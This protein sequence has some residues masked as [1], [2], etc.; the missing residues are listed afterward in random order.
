M[1]EQPRQPRQPSRLLS[2]EALAEMLDVSVYTVKR[3]RRER[4]GPRG[5]RVGKHIRYRAADV[6]RW[7]EQ[8][9][10]PESAA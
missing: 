7:L 8:R 5:V 2:I 9:A 10:D 4:T 6:E 3:W 1:A